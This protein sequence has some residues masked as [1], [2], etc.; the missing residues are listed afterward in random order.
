MGGANPQQTDTAQILPHLPLDT[1]LPMKKEIYQPAAGVRGNTNP[2]TMP[3]YPLHPSQAL[4]DLRA[5]GATAAPIGKQNNQ[6]GVILTPEQAAFDRA[7]TKI[8][9]NG[10]P[11]E[12]YRR[13]AK[14]LSSL[15]QIEQGLKIAETA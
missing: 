11:E 8:E 6:G 13:D 14:P 7:A 12:K 4:Q 10:Q 15:D 9:K 3:K 1:S 5:A 2:V